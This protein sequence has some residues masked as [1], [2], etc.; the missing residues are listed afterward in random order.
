MQIIET[1]FSWAYPLIDRAQTRRIVVHHAAATKASAEAIHAGHLANGWS[2]IGYHYYVRKDGTVYRGRPEHKKGSHAGSAANSDSI[3]ICFEGNFE[4]DIMGEDQFTAGAELIADILSR[5]S[6]L[7]IMGHR[8]VGA[9]ACPGANFPL[10]QM[11]KKAQ[12]DKTDMVRYERLSDI[13]DNWDKAGN[14][15]ATI[16]L[17]MNAKI[18][19]GDGSDPEGNNDVIDLSHD[20]VRALIFEY[21]GGAFD[22]KL[23]AQGFP[24]AVEV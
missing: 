22:R 14:P 24:Q 17:L 10:E 21:R 8:S 23:I 11:I 9:T 4:T 16:E 19:A 12:E 1:N 5:Y 7:E 15:R 20:M 3:G 13:P 6:T 2:G 18:L